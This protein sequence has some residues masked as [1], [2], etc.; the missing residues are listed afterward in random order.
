[1]QTYLSHRPAVLLW[2]DAEIKEGGGDIVC[3]I[4]E[5]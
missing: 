3:W 1:M 4:G 2:P 5:G